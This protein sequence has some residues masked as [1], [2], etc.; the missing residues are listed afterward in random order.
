MQDIV[1]LIRYD[2]TV[3]TNQLRTFLEKYIPRFQHAN[4]RFVQ[5]FC[6]KVNKYN[7][8]PGRLELTMEDAHALADSNAALEDI[9]GNSSLDPTYV[10]ELMRKMMLGNSRIWETIAFFETIQQDNPEFKY[11]IMKNKKGQPEAVLWS[12][13]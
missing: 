10:C 9:G 1:Q 13:V 4:S 6:D 11:A 3:P 8:L 7:A 2:H 5:K 12:T